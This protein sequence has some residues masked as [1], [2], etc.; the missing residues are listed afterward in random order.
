MSTKQDSTTRQG[1]VQKWSMCKFGLMQNGD[2]SAKF[3]LCKYW[4]EKI[5]VRSSVSGQTIRFLEIPEHDG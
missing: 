1:Q 4:H 5:S 2:A 3:K